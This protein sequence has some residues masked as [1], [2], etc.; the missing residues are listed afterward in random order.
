MGLL[1]TVSE[2]LK[3]LGHGAV[4]FSPTAPPSQR[5][6][7]GFQVL[8]SGLNTMNG[9]GELTGFKP[10]QK[11]SSSANKAFGGVRDTYNE[12]AG[13]KSTYD[14]IFGKSPFAA[15]AA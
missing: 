2:G 3:T 11:V 14:Q 15:H 8:S 13:I 7:S 10:L 5:I 12:V 6:A 1:G 4:A 9:V